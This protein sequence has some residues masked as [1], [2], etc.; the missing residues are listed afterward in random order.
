MGSEMCIRDRDMMGIPESLQ[1][2]LGLDDDGRGRG[3]G[4]VAAGTGL[5]PVVTP[6]PLPTSSV[7]NESVSRMSMAI[8]V[9]A[10]WHP[11]A[12][13]PGF[14]ECLQRDRSASAHGVCGTGR[15]NFKSVQSEHSAPPGARVRPPDEKISCSSAEKNRKKTGKKNPGK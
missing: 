12:G 2:L 13:P 4:A 9:R 11:R 5:G 1:A 14:R 15:P 3:A 8:P 7:N 10:I 6:R